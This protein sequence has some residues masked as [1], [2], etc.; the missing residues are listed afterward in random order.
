[1]ICPATPLATAS[2]L[3]MV[4]VR[5]TAIAESPYPFL[6]TTRATVVPM[7]AGL[8]TVVMPAASIA[9]IFSAAV[10]LPPAMM[11]PAWP[12]RRPGGAVWPQMNPTTGLVT[13]AL[14]KGGGP[15]P[16]RAPQ[17]P[18]HRRGEWGLDEG[19][20]LLLGGAA[21]LP[22]HHDR[23]RLGIGLEEPQHVDEVG[24][25]DRIAADAHARRLPEPALGE[26]MD[27]LVG[28]RAA[29]RDHPHVAHLVDVAGHDADLGLARRDQARAVRADEPARGARGEGLHP[30][31]CRPRHPLGDADDQRDPRVRRFHDG[32]C[33]RRRGHEDQRAIGA[34]RLHRLLHRVPD[35]AAL[36]DGGAPARRRPAPPRPSVLPAAGRVEGA[37]LAGDSLHQD[38]RRAADQD[39]H[40]RAPR[41]S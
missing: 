4:R 36:V 3:M 27:H 7:S 35:R 19:G 13:W 30:H 1:M 20:G 29:A 14:T 12:M 41:T 24:A 16:A 34:G 26:L 15:S 9:A 10:P 28:E 5:W 31:P 22:D 8:L 6:P 21:D 25:G 17:R 18:A 39:A 2:G 11:A 38:A 40:E 37:R 33:G 32:V 23:G